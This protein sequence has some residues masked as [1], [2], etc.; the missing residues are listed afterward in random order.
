M[1][2]ITHRTRC[3]LKINSHV[4]E[5]YPQTCNISTSGLAY[6]NNLYS[7]VFIRTYFLETKAIPMSS[8]SSRHED[9]LPH[10]LTKRGRGES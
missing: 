6:V 9:V 7:Y 5:L 1:A 8:F 4:H 3:C 2:Q 10:F